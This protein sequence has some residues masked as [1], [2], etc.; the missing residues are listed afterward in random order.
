MST[1][2]WFAPEVAFTPRGA[3]NLNDHVCLLICAE[4]RE[5]GRS[6]H[7]DFDQT[8]LDHCCS[9][10][11]FWVIGIPVPSL[12]AAVFGSLVG[13]LLATARLALIS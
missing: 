7:N 6:R 1:D 10:V 13:W 9:G 12:A 4:L 5:G 2:M 3:Q 11:Q 8:R